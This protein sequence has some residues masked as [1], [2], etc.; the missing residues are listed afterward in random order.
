VKTVYIYPILCACLIV[1]FLVFLPN[2]A[3]VSLLHEDKKS[4]VRREALVLTAVTLLYAGIAFWNLGNTTAPKTY[5][6]FGAEVSS[7]ILSSGEEHELGGIALYCQIGTG[8]YTFET[9]SDGVVW[10]SIGTFEQDYVSLLKWHFLPD[11]THT[12]DTPSPFRYFRVTGWGDAEMGELAVF[13]SDGSIIVWDYT[14]E[15]NDEQ[16]LIPEEYN[17]HNSSYFDEIYHARTALEYLRGENAY[18]ISHPPLGKLI[19]GVGIL[20]F[21]MN[22]F[23]W[24]FM[25]TL[26]G[27]LMLPL[28]Y[29]LAKKIFR[30]R[31]AA[32][33]CAILFA[34]DFMH[35]VQTRIATI[36][37]YAVFFILLMYYFMYIFI[38]EET[39]GSLFLSGLFF[40]I[41]CASKWTCVYA[42]GGL[43]VIWAVYWV[44]HIKEYGFKAFF[45][46]SMKCVGFFILVPLL[47][48]YLSYIPYGAAIGLR[49]PGMLL[50]KEYLQV[51]LD[52]Q[53]F[54]FNYHAGIVATHPYS[55]KWYQ[56]LLDIRPILYYLQYYPDGSRVSFGAF[57]NPVICWTGLI[58]V[59]LLIPMYFLRK[60]RRAGFLLVGY[61]AQLL[62]WVLI[63]RLTFAYHYFP[64]VVFLVLAIGYFI[65]LMSTDRIRKAA[66]IGFVGLS[67]LVFIYFYPV[68]AGTKVNS[69]AVSHLFG[70]FPT[71]PF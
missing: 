53:S 13:S 36:D 12:L 18:E 7:V 21:G 67:V 32:I 62:P 44:R 43:A 60:D 41:G 69:Y 15:L 26:F 61:L 24:R 17:Y 6:R 63:E 11:T 29:A 38:T 68:L 1:L 2:L 27:V 66:C 54:M 52:N 58:C 16:S 70:W 23:G 71:W 8:S 59:I 48:Y 42:G 5:V 49:G 65:S 9:S 51:V 50:K 20:L 10:Q 40:G 35:F 25:G 47:V 37:V 28:M 57:V 22:P 31:F 45:L 39:T 34:S 30:N 55:S 4:S 56:W 46:N 19:I 64:C 3:K 33:C 14:T